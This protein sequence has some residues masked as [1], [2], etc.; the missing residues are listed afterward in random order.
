M[1]MQEL[2][3]GKHKE[4]QEAVR[5][6]VKERNSLKAE[7]SSLTKKVSGAEAHLQQ[8][9]RHKKAIDKQLA[10]SLKKTQVSPL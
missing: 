5:E 4:V 8:V 9:A 1:L 3:T 2:N 6:V 10:A 7:V